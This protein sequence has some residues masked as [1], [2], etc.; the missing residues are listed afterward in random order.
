LV[1]P[2]TPAFNPVPSCTPGFVMSGTDRRGSNPLTLSF[3]INSK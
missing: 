3:V 2:S 1:V